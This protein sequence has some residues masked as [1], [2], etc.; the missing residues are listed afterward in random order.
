MKRDRF[1]RLHGN[2]R[3]WVVAYRKPPGR[4][5]TKCFAYR[6]NGGPVF[7]WLAACDQVQA[8][9]DKFPDAL[10]YRIMRPPTPL[11]AE[12]FLLETQ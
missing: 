12:Q 2:S 7:A 6:A 9:L 3:N 10:V 1:G 11:L 4:W 5:S 8:W